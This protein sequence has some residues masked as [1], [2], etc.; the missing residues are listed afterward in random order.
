MWCEVSI[1]CHFEI[2]L[3][4]LY[5]SKLNILLKLISPDLVFSLMWL[6]AHLWLALY[7]NWMAL[8][9]PL[10][11]GKSLLLWLLSPSLSGSL[12]VISECWLPP[13][14]LLSIDA[15]QDSVLRPVLLSHDM[16]LLSDPPHLSLLEYAQPLT[17]AWAS[18]EWFQQKVHWHLKLTLHAA[19]PTLLPLN[20]DLPGCPLPV[21]VPLSL[22]PETR[23]K[24]DSLMPHPSDTGPHSFSLLNG[25]PLGLFMPAS[26]LAE[27]WPACPHPST[28]LAGPARVCV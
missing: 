28:Q 10:P 17:F 16:L 11:P 1:F 18:A 3:F 24:L 26:G 22:V 21:N 27:L 15:S 5:R 6:L 13:Q 19:H 8:L 20:H 23:A 12:G 9:W 25:L 4:W 7:F 2:I 14:Q